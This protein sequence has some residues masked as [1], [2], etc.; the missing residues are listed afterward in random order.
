MAIDSNKAKRELLAGQIAEHVTSTLKLVGE[1]PTREGLDKTPIRAAKAMLDNLRGYAQDPVEILRSA[2]FEHEGSDMII[3][4]DVEFYSLCEHHILP[5]FGTVTIGY[6][7]NGR[8]A[9]LSK[10]ARAVDAVAR[11]LQVQERLTAQ[12]AQ[13]IQEALEP[14]GVIVL[15]KAQ[16]LCMM[17]RGIEKQRSTTVTS[18]YTGDF[19]LSQ[20]REDFYRSAAL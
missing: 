18:H 7:P 15:C 5:F 16:H 9:G 4:R 6:I 19:E 1:D 3:V 2:T 20:L 13:A 10:F 8:I 14:K 11:R 12:V 17:M